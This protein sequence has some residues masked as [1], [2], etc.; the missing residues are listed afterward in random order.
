MRARDQFSEIFSSLFLVRHIKQSIGS[1]KTNKPGKL[2]PQGQRQVPLDLVGSNGVS[3]GSGVMVLT[4]PGAGGAAIIPWTACGCQ[5]FCEVTG[6]GLGGGSAV[7]NPGNP[8]PV[9]KLDRVW[10]LA[11]K[12]APPLDVANTAADEESRERDGERVL[13]NAP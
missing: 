10:P 12:G 7:G 2:H 1:R 4:A 3:L 6:C 13:I 8:L 11:R 5:W 9:E